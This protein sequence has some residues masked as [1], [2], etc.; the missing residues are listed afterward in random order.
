MIWLLILAGVLFLI[1]QGGNIG[2]WRTVGDRCWAL[3]AAFASS[4]CMAAVLLSL[5]PDPPVV[6]THRE[7]I[8][9]MRASAEAAVASYQRENAQ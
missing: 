7:R 6:L 3:G 2:A 8:E 5:R 1:S 4:L 9:A